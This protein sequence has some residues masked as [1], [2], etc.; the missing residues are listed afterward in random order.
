MAERSKVAQMAE[1]EAER[2]EAE[3]PDDET[4]E[5]EEA[6]QSPAEPQPEPEQPPEPSPEKLAQ[7]EQITQ[8]ERAQ[9]TYLKRVEKILGPEAMPGL[10]PTC[11]GTALNFAGHEAAPDYHT[12]EKYITCESC[13]GLG[14]VLTGSRVIGAETQDCPECMGRGYLER[15]PTV[16]AVP[17]Q[18]QEYGTPSW[19]GTAPPAVVT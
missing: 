19:M 10:C 16:A 6:E 3:Q 9:E 13:A 1:A 7:A 17:D 4:T 15:L 18:A 5:Q 2:A 14:K 11:N 12:H 8:L